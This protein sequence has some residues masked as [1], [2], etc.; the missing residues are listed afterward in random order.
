MS[1]LIGIVGTSYC[2]STL[3]SFILGSHPEVF[4]TSELNTLFRQKEKTQCSICKEECSF[5]TK[6]FVKDLLNN[7]KER[8]FWVAEKANNDLDK[9]ITVFSDKNPKV[10]QA[11][12]IQCNKYITLFKRPEALVNSYKIHNKS[13]NL[14]DPLQLY[15][16]TYNSSFELSNNE[17]IFYDDFAKNP[18]KIIKYLCKDIDIKYSKDMLDFWNHEHH[19]ISGNSG[20]HMHVWGEERR[21]KTFDTPYWKDVYS[22]EHTQFIKDYYREIKLD[23]KWKEQLTEEEKT[24][25]ENHAPS[26]LIFEKLMNLRR[27]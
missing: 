19:T 21:D 23:E 26:K 14:N 6:E 5:W 20:V 25:I 12:K 22:K 9:T 1:K 17:Y 7:I 3:L 13:E 8:Y 16:E 2:G 10:Y 24:Y 18:E 27:Y 11:S 15:I 4:A